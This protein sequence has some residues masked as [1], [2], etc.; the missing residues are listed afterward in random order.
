MQILRNAHRI[1][2]FL[3]VWFALYLGVA[4][5]SPM[6]NP[7]SFELICSSAGVMKL[8]VQANDDA[9]VASGAMLDCPLCATSGA[10]PSTFQVNCGSLLPLGHVMQS[11]P[12]PVIAALSAAP[13][14]A[15]GPPADS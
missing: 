8:V 12:A 1:T 6:V 14:P 13:L 5:A 2:R 11:I 15:R 10:P 4:V 7:Q 3:L 9:K